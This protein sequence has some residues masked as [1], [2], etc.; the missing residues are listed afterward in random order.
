MTRYDL[1][2]FIHIAGAVTWA[3]AG[4]LIQ[5]LVYRANRAR[6]E[7]TIR[8]LFNE[9]G[10]LSKVI[11]IPASLAVGVFGIVMVVD[12][13]LS[14]DE[15]WLTL[16]LIGY[17]ATFVTGIGIISPK[18]ERIGEQIERD[19]GTVTPSSLVEIQKLL[20]LLRID[21]VVLYLVVAVMAI[22]P[23]GDD[24]GLLI[25]M[26]AIL[27]AGVALVASQVRGIAT[28]SKATT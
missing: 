5:V 7:G 12:G 17:I 15:L 22:K 26:A 27:I 28:P 8:Y 1:Y 4:V 23:T 21:T 16:G 13:P 6:D 9:I 19:G 24:A 10:V 20:A 11:F 18:T 25:V 3:G 2:K 14:F